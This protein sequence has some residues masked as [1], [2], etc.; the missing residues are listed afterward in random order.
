MALVWLNYQTDLGRSY[1]MVNL[2]V[3][4]V[5]EV[6]SN[7]NPIDLLPP[8]VI[9]QVRRVRNSCAVADLTSRVLMLWLIDGAQYRLT[10][11]QPFSQNLFDFLTLNTD[12]QAFEF[13]GERVKYGR[14]RRMLDNV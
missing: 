8:A 11:P 12:V 9:S 13:V 4:Q 7:I 10:Y 14:L 2:S 6:D 1:P 3:G 5:N